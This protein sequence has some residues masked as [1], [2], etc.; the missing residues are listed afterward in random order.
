LSWDVDSDSQTAKA[1]S[2]NTRELL[3]LRASVERLS[4][5]Q[6]YILRTLGETAPAAVPTPDLISVSSFKKNDQFSA[7]TATLAPELILLIHRLTCFDL[8]TRAIG[9]LRTDQVWLGN[10]E[11]ERA[12]HVEP[13][14]AREVEGKLISLCKE[15]RDNFAGLRSRS[16]MV[17]VESHELS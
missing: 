6:S 11:G 12:T 17:M 7:V 8:P 1:L 10:M 13:P 5:G 4:T 9:R 15:W 16:W 14:P 2:A 3:A